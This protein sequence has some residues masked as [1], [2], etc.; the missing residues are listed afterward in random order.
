MEYQILG[1]GS[2]HLDHIS[3][4]YIRKSKIIVVPEDPKRSTPLIRCSGYLKTAYSHIAASETGL[5]LVDALKYAQQNK[6][7]EKD[8][9]PVRLY[10][11][12][13]LVEYQ[14]VETLDDDFNLA[15]DVKRVPSINLGVKHDAA[16]SHPVLG[17]FFVV[18]AE[19]SSFVFPHCPMF[20]FG[21]GYER[22][23]LE[24]MGRYGLW[25]SVSDSLSVR[26]RVERYFSLFPD[27]IVL[28]QRYPS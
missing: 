18:D 13:V 5:H 2:P 24:R 14:V 9:I 11:F 1:R 6:H 4:D 10:F 26:L 19:N 20:N 15:L 21:Q 22:L 3:F 28:L 25:L 7:C 17:K 23:D 8:L 27:H 12:V 16:Q